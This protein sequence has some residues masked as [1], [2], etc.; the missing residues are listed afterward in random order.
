MIRSLFASLTAVATV[1]AFSTAAELK[2]GPQ[3]GEKVPGPFTP[4]NING[5]A[6]GQKNCLYCSNGNNPVAVVF[7]RTADCPMTQ[8]L[9]QEL[10]AATAKNS[11]CEMGSY[12][13]FL[14]D[15]EKLE[16]KLKELVTEK[17]LK[18]IVLSIDT[19][20]GPA[21]YKISKDADVTVVLYTERSTKVNH[22][23][24][25]GELDTAAIKTIVS[26]VSKI[27]K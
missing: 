4:L 23:F 12:V 11:A 16:A 9:I 26:E 15:E 22:A 3:P 5:S 7:A 13:V 6:A 25:K 17:G 24:K 10:D 20:T 1:A 18:K 27:T 19:P 21:K 8:K 14:S 2:S